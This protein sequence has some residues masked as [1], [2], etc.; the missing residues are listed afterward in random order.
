VTETEPNDEFAKAP[1]IEKLPTTINGRLNKSG[2]VDSYAVQLEAGRSVRAAI[3]A[4][5]LGSPVDAVIRVVDTRGLELALNHDNGRNL[6]PSLT[7]TAGAAGTYVLQIFG[8]AHPAT[9]DVRFTGSDACVYRLHLSRGPQARYTL[10]LGMTRAQPAKLRV[11]GWNLRD[12]AGREFEVDG[13]VVSA[14]SQETTWQSPDFENALAIPLGDGPEWLEQDV[15]T[16]PADSPVPPPPFAITGCIEKIG[17]EDRF[18]FAAT[19]GDKLVLEIR[20]ASLGFP[21]DAWLAIQNSDGK[22]LVRADDGPN[23]DPL[24]EWTAPETGSYVAAVGSVLHRAGAD[25]LYRLS[26]QRAQ[27]RFQAVIA[28]SGFA[29]E[30]GKTIKIKIT[31]RRVQGFKA[32]L[33]ASVAGLP[34]GLSAGTVELGETEKEITVDVTAAAEA[35]PFAGPIQIH[36]READSDTAIAA[37]HEL[38]STTLKNGVP[39][40]FRDLVIPS[41]D[42][43]WLTV[44][45]APKSTATG[46][47]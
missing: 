12:I 10:P 42:R 43:I 27:P 39:Q 8:F 4:Y 35:P 13:S 3:D 5:V 38:V 23:A 41:T 24:L 26:I 25:H 37:V 45:P 40:G 7:W 33:T 28:E 29:V 47:K 32:R 17:E 15:M 31:A 21:L 1:L 19:K 2:D 11:F 44:L 14:G 9:A 20:S 46:E 34:E 30:P 18:D 22:E 36:F 6:D 16:R